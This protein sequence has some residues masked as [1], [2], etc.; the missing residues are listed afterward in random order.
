LLIPL[1]TSI[2]K[3]SFNTTK[4]KQNRQLREQKEAEFSKTERMLKLVSG[5]NK[6]KE[7]S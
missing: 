7:G 6:E 2:H 4:S 5:T 1:N 3:A